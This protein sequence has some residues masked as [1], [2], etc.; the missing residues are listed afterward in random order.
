[1]TDAPSLSPL[2]AAVCDRITPESLVALTSELVAI[3]SLSGQEG[4]IQ[5]WLAGRLTELGMS[6]ET[7]D[8][9]MATLAQHPAFSSEVDRAEAVAVLGR[10]GSGRG[11]TLLIDAHVDV[12]PPGHE[13]D[14]ETPAF[15]PAVRDGRVYGRGACDMKGGLA[16]AA[17]AMSAIAASGIS[18]SG[19]VILACVV[20]EE[21]GGSGTL[22]VL[23][24][25][26]RADGCL[27]P[28]P[29]GGA[30]VPAVAGALSWRITVRGKSAHGCLREEGVSA[31]EKFA[32]V[33]RAVLDLEEGR[34]ARSSPGFEWLTRPF[35]ICGG[36]IVGGD[37]PSSEC[38][39]LVWEGRYGVSPEEDL[40]AARAE[41]EEAVAAACASDPWLA[42]HPASIEWWGGQF[43]PART[44]LDDPIVTTTMAAVTD[45][46]GVAPQVRGMPY[47]CDA[48]LTVGVAGI[49]TVVLGPGDIRD[50]HAPNESV[51]ITNLVDAARVIAVSVLRFCGTA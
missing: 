14:W 12:V 22:G 25:G 5:T 20:G 16:A 51:T 24:H 7:I 28:E 36:R 9:D 1:M 6:V 3:P 35:A 23:E 18:L 47:G 8:L 30:L 46:T 40:A 33:H 50:A 17:I 27:I 37:W 11:R 10:I 31:I 34:N 29:T 48:G 21:D 2:E 19:T 45:V 49:P 32:I 43:L 39:W 44:S 4:G 42:A 38:D 13:E 26:I 15:A 41:F